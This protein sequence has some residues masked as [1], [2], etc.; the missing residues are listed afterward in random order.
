MACV[1]DIS[2]RRR[3]LKA[4]FGLL[5]ITF[6]CLLAWLSIHNRMLPV[7]SWAAVTWPWTLLTLATVNFARSALKAGSLIGPG[8]LASTACGALVTGVGVSRSPLT[9]VVLACAAIL[10]GVVLIRSSRSRSQAGWTRVMT[11][12]RVRAPV[13]VGQHTPHPRL[14][15]R[16]IAGEVRA[17]FGGSNLDGS[18]AVWVT[19]IS[20]HVHL[21]VPRTWPV[22]VRSAGIALTRVTDTHNP[23]DTHAEDAHSLGLHLLGLCAAITLVR[24]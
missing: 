2:R 16:A 11:T 12:G 21:T 24:A 20:G 8:L 5:S 18:L 23:R 4:L 6:G 15:L 9:I 7:E 10:T 19:A 3:H 1:I 13:A 14:T 17:D 22:V